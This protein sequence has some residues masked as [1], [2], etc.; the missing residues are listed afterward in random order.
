M[1]MIRRLPVLIAL[2]STLLISS[3]YL[4]PPPPRQPSPDTAAVLDKVLQD[5]VLARAGQALATTIYN[6]E[7]D[8]AF[9][10]EDGNTAVLWLALRERGSGRRVAGEP[11]LAIAR[12]S[13]GA[14]LGW[15]LVM[16]SDPGWE[17]AFAALPEDL[18]PEHVRVRYA[19]PPEEPD[20][21]KG[22][23]RGYKL[24]W[25][26]GLAKRLEAS[27]GHYL[28]YRPISC[29][30]YMCRYALDFYD[31]TMFPLLASKAGTVWMASDS[32]PN[33]WESCYNYLVLRDDTTTPVTYQLYLHLAYD[34]IPDDFVPGRRVKQGEYI[35]R[36]DDTGFSTNHHLH[37]HVHTS[38]TSYWAPS[39]DFRYDDVPV[40]DGAPRTCLEASLYPAYG[41]ECIGD[42]INPMK[43][44]NDWYVSGNVGAYPPKGDLLHPAPGAS[45]AGA[46]MDVT[47]TASDDQGVERVELVAL[48]DGEWRTAGPPLAR[49]PDGTYD[50]DVPLCAAGLTHGSYEIAL[51][52]QDME[53]NVT[54]SLPGRR[55]I[56]VSHTCPPPSS[57]LLPVNPG[58]VP[59]TAVL[60]GWEAQESGAGIGGFE[61]Q[62]RPAGGSWAAAASFPGEARQGWFLGQ[63]GGTYD[64]RLRAL[65][66]YGQAEPFPSEPEARVTFAASCTPDALEPDDAPGDSTPPPGQARN[67]CPLGDVDWALLEVTGE[68]PVLLWAEPLG[69]PANLL[70]EVFAADD[71]TAPLWAARS[72]DFGQPALGV[73]R[74]AAPGRCYVRVRAGV[75]GLAGD[76]VR[77]R[78]KAVPAHTQ[79]LPAAGK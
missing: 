22:P 74:P 7:T 58:T 31:G 77:Y 75:E 68:Q 78:L 42:K 32:C 25:A 65:D 48:V 40:N 14:R 61:L 30:E 33:G 4:S 24:P 45:I 9:L 49:Q 34:S 11:G 72:P 79:Y 8:S 47:A 17:E 1:K 38:P 27:I 41:S 53:G 29:D 71:L 66:R 64:L 43:A 44:T 15:E 16:Q 18:L 56:T 20:S 2:L 5:G 39:V 3:S 73:F 28:V 23:L 10:S 6:V 70:V 26:A 21:P 57:R 67:L 54:T 55:T 35:G 62:A 13:T 69:E 51:R 60:L 59:A 76:A 37:F 52:I 63:P 19:R 12:R 46:V 36:D 50:G